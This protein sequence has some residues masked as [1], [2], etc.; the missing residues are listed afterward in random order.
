MRTSSGGC[1]SS[2]QQRIQQAS[3][4]IWLG[5]LRKPCMELV[6]L[7]KA[8]STL[9]K[10][11]HWSWTSQSSFE[12]PIFKHCIALHCIAWH[13]MAWHGMAWH[14]MACHG[15][16]WHGMAWHYIFRLS[17]FRMHFK[18]NQCALTLLSCP[19]RHVRLF[20]GSPTYCCSAHVLLA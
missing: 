13:G 5:S 16:A 6:M 18:N 10:R 15:M 20:D 17:K 8:C 7:L 11:A 4:G 2:S 19:D 14:G 12:E 3:V 1:T 9:L